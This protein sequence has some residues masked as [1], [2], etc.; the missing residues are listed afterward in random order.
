MAIK[1]AVIES[2]IEKW[3]LDSQEPQVGDGSNTEDAKISNAR[4]RGQREGIQQCASQLRTLMGI[5]STNEDQK[6]CGSARQ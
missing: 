1:N 3:I 2:I 5:L 4:A 6:I